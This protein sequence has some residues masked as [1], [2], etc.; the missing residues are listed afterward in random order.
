MRILQVNTTD[1][2]GGA[3]RAAYRLNLGLRALGQQSGMFVAR[4]AGTDPEVVLFTPPSSL[5]ERIVPR[6]R[7]VSVYL[8]YAR[9]NRSRPSGYELFRTDRNQYTGTVL[10]QL[11]SCDVMNLHWIADFIDYA[12]FF[13]GI[14]NHIPLV[15]TLH[16]MNPFTGGCHYDAGCGCF[17]A[18]C[19]QC[20]QL[21]SSSPRDLSERTWRRK[22]EVF[23]RISPQRLHIVTPSRWLAQEV[24]NSSLMSRFPVSVIPNSL[25]TDAFSPLDKVMARTALG[26]PLD[27]RAVLF[28]SESTTKERKGF[29]YL[30]QALSALAD[31]PGIHLVSLG[32]GM[33]SVD[34]SI[35][36]LHLGSLDS[37]RLLALAYSAADLFVIPS[38]QD[39]LPNT[40][41]E[42][43]ACGT[44]VV[45]FDVGG[46]PD[47]VRPGETGMLTP[48][49]DSAGL[50]N[51][52]RSLL[53]NPA[54]RAGLSA[55]CR[56]VAVEEYSPAVQ[57]QRY[58]DLYRSL[59]GKD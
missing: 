49:R 23:G 43:F 39:N 20:P 35:P 40:V 15:W 5:G 8:D 38:L 33:P 24:R 55:N 44:P 12:S 56:R 48:L 26:L 28:I 16:D 10:K 58:L 52:I 29:V 36:H 25:D 22:R 54:L 19:G 57:A 9:Y 4:R 31:L 47:M 53:L 14:P 7:G 45:G 3:A 17:R 42:S 6:L 27:A 59:T 1:I 18:S 30:A 51:A 34:T 46:I 50:G 37:D 21:G 41:L 13:S 11:P 2:M 32:R